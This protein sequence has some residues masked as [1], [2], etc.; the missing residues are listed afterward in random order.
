M[1]AERVE[2]ELE[3]L[4]HGDRCAAESPDR[5]RHANRSRNDPA[6][7]AQTFDR[8]YAQTDLRML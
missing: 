8:N 2:R 4:D 1:G 3:R 7:V 5:K 6:D